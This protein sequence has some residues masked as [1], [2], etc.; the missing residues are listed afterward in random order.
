MT[1]IGVTRLCK[2]NRA[3]LI[4]SKKCAVIP[5]SLSCSRVPVDLVLIERF[6]CDVEFISHLLTVTPHHPLLGF[7]A[8]GVIKTHAT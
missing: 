3:V 8:D 4:L 1:L 7:T 2:R 5:Q 6:Y